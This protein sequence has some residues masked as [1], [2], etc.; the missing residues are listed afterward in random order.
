MVLGGPMLAIPFWIRAVWCF[1]EHDRLVAAAVGAGGPK[2]EFASMEIW[3]EGTLCSM[4][5]VWGQVA[6]IAGVLGLVQLR[7]AQPRPDDRPE[8]TTTSEDIAEMAPCQIKR[9]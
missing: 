6:I 8:R 9:L 4:V 7:L 3:I 5:S 1:A 2:S